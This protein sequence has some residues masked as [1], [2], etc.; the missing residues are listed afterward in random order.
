MYIYICVCVCVC[1]CVRLA[2]DE[3]VGIFFIDLDLNF[4]P[5]LKWFQILLILIILLNFNH[6]TSFIPYNIN[7]LLAHR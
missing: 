3:V 7:H 2:V 5:R 6:L 1:V 4:L